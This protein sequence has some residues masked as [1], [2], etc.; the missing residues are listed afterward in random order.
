M[1][2]IRSVIEIGTSKIICLMDVKKRQ[3]LDMLGSACVRYDGIRDGKWVRFSSVKES[4]E[5]AISAAENKAK[6]QLRSVYVGVPGCFTRVV[7][8]QGV[9]HMSTGLVTDEEIRS[10]GKKLTPRPESEWRLIDSRPLYFID[11]RE[12]LY[13]GPPIGLRTSQLLACF[14]YVFANREFIKDIEEIFSQLHIRIERFVSEVEAQALHYIPREER[15]RCALLLDIGYQS[16]SLSVVFGDGIMAH[17]PFFLGGRNIVDALQKVLGTDGVLAE[18]L[19]RSHVFGIGSGQ[20]DQVYG[21]NA[22]GKME[23]FDANLVREIVDDSVDLLCRLVSKQIIKFSKYIT[24]STS[25]YLMGA[26]LAMHGVEP[27]LGAKL[28]RKIIVPKN[29]AQR[30]LP[31][32]YNSALALLDIHALTVYHLDGQIVPKS[33]W[34]TLKYMFQK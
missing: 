3:G 15:D 21:K 32:F 23:G 17:A 31:P 11:D 13:A 10:M 4:I 18:N 22:Q 27:Y 2:N 33:I 5:N 12:E 28:N 30:T 19:K 29:K 16:S 26:G 25:I 34:N 24:K 14:S 6:V 9:K 8:V 1:S 7:A 20:D